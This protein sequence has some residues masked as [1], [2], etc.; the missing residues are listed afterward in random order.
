ML[1]CHLRDIISSFYK[2]QIVYL[3]P[4]DRKE[5]TIPPSL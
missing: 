2:H 1:L 3:R 5:N 4:A